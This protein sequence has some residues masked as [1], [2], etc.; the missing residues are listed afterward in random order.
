NHGHK[1]NSHTVIIDRLRDAA[2]IAHMELDKE[3]NS[4]EET[5]STIPARFR[6]R[7][8]PFS[9]E[10]EYILRLCSIE[11]ELTYFILTGD[12]YRG[13]IKIGYSARIRPRVS[14]IKGSCPLK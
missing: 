6:R 11:A 1:A 5:I 8:V 3:I 13:F 9:A 2:A 4:E 14:C 10:E 7:R 12:N